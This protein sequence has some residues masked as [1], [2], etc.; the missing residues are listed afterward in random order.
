MSAGPV[1]DDLAQAVADHLGDGWAHDP[2]PDHRWNRRLVHPSGR[3]I[4]VSIDR[5]RLS[6][7]AGSPWV[8]PDDGLGRMDFHYGY[9]WPRISVAL[10]RGAAAAAAEVRRRLL[11]TYEL[12]WEKA[13]RAIAERQAMLAV[14]RASTARL[15]AVL[16]PMHP[17]R[18]SAEETVIHWRQGDLTV[19]LMSDGTTV[20]LQAKVPLAAAEAIIAG[21]IAPLDGQP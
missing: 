7:C 4:F 14:R 10:G 18:V 5:D 6:L 9:E 2:D 21:H 1:S 17:P 16:A 15:T 12:S 19:Q 20:L 13:Q 8:N 11:P 3:H